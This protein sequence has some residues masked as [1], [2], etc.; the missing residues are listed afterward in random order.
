[1]GGAIIAAG[2]LDTHDLLMLR[3]YSWALPLSIISEFLLEKIRENPKFALDLA[4]SEGRLWKTIEIF[5]K[6]ENG[7]T[8]WRCSLHRRGCDAACFSALLAEFLGLTLSPSL[9]AE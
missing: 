4:P 3:L 9:S 7:L 1:M 5:N 6:K 2:F 8:L